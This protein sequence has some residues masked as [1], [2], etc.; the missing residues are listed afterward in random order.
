MIRQQPRRAHP[1]V[2][3]PVAVV[4]PDA[5]AGGRH[6]LA[7]NDHG[8][9]PEATRRVLV[10]LL[11]GPYVM[12]E[13]HPLLWPA[14][15]RD[16]DAVRERLGDLFLVLVLDR[17]VG[18]AYV[19]ALTSPTQALPRT[20]RSTPLTLIDTALVLHLRGLLLRAEA[21]ATRVFVGR[22]E[23][24]DHLGVYRSATG[25]DPVTFAKRVNASVMK[26]KNN[27]VLLGTGEEERF[28][29]S[30]ILGLVFDADEVIAVTAEL[31]RLVTGV[32]GGEAADD[33]RES[34]DDQ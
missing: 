32:P 12:R 10:Q 29:I 2:L 4:V 18:L 28:E 33:E 7:E 19:K 26:M 25:T 13:R 31:R 14:L 27:S 30:P 16:E 21:S 22:D 11:S 23:I 15:L 34:E 3:P 17:E 24:D 5:D 9:L 8:R 6:R 20:L 1:D